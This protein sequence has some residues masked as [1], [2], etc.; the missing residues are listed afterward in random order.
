MNS[1]FASSFE[2]DLKKIRDAKVLAAV[3]SAILLVEAA[4]TLQDIPN[5]KKLKGS[6]K[7]DSF[8]IK[9]GDWRIGIIIENQ[10]IVFIACDH[11]KDIYTHFP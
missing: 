5:L 1:D 4:D 6:K 10:T 7:G 3:K 11:R 9:I 8:R 2:R